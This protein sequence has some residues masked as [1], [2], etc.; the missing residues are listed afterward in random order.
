MYSRLKSSIV[1][2][3]ALLLCALPPTAS[4]QSV[5]P[6]SQNVV[7][8]SEIFIIQVEIQNT[9][10]TSQR[11]EIYLYDADWNRLTPRYISSA[12]PFLGPGDKMVITAMMTFNGQNDRKVYI[13]NTI[14]P[15]QGGVGT[16]FRGEVCGKVI[17][18][19]LSA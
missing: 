17:A 7:S 8:F 13:C 16:A 14:T 5:A 9:Y 11:N 3:G 12:A 1:L 15:R 6:M 2:T 10:S 18:T 19:R 4:A